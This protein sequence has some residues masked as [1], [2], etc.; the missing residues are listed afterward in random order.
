MATT[1]PPPHPDP[2]PPGLKLPPAS[3]DAHCHIFGPGALFPYAENRTFTPPDVSKDDLR[4]RHDFL[5]IERAVIVQSSCHGG[6]H[7]ALLD[8]L[9][10]GAGRYRGVALVTAGTPEAEI[11]RLDAAGVCGARVHFLPHLGPSPSPESVD[12]VIRLIRPYGWHLAVHVAGRGI[13]D[14]ADRIRSAALPVIIDHMARVDVH[15]E[16]ATRTLLRLLDTG[17]VWVKLSGADRLSTA[18]PPYEDVAPFAGRLAAHAPERVL[19]GT[20]FPHPNISGD[21]PD[22]GL[23][24]DFLGRIAPTEALRRRILVDNPAAVFGF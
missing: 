7:A 8:A 23:L 9:A 10:D 17:H 2:K 3:C 1:T 13:L 15:D 24:V 6:D 20:D 14:L 19:W 16:R 21:M 5:G 11:A 12:A 18:G 22:D 4:R